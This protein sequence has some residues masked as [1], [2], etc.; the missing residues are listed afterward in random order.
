M[1]SA[2][3]STRSAALLQPHLRPARLPGAK[4]GPSGATTTTIVTPVAPEDAFDIEDFTTASDWEK[5]AAQAEQALRAWASPTDQNEDNEEKEG[6]KEDQQGGAQIGWKR[7]RRPLHFR[8][9]TFYL[10]RHTKVSASPMVPEDE[11]DWQDQRAEDRISLTPL[12][13]AALNH[14]S[15]FP[16][17][18]HPVHYFFGFDDFAVLSAGQPAAAINDS[19]R[20]RAAISTLA[21]AATAAR[22]GGAGGGGGELPLLAEMASG[23]AHFEGIF[24]TPDCRGEL[25]MAVL[26]RSRDCQHLQDVMR[27]L[28][29]RLCRPRRTEPENGYCVASVRK[30]YLLEDWSGRYGWAGASPDADLLFSVATAAAAASNV[31]A[32]ASFTDPGRLPMGSGADPVRKMWLH[33]TWRRVNEDLAI[34]N[35]IHTDLYPMEAPSWSVGIEF[36][37]NVHGFLGMYCMYKYVHR[38]YSLHFRYDPTCFIAGDYL[39][40]F[41]SLCCRQETMKDLLGRGTAGSS[42]GELP[43]ESSEASAALNRLTGPTYGLRDIIN[44]GRSDTKGVKEGNSDIRRG[45]SPHFA[46][47]STLIVGPINKAH[48][49]HILEFLFPDSNPDSKHAYPEDLGS[50]RVHGSAAAGVK[51]AP[52]GG[53]LWRLSVVMAHCLH[54]MGKRC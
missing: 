30:S 53:I 13:T 29:D 54:L 9:F 37:D 32:L 47:I 46:T 27:L 11:G 26:P 36:D 10:T 6:Q 33:T 2:S 40:E 42:V 48:L 49:S 25:E 16:S 50:D 8:D 34:E 18:S 12:L 1:T 20:M 51:S 7:D 19:S 31:D 38:L 4:G 3:S 24:I 28:R 5:W 43:S 14:E 15:D 35:A 52:V 44:A 45:T 39:R 21:S 41:L 22:G 23:K 17:Q